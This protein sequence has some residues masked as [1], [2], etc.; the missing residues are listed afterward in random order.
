MQSKFEKPLFSF[1]DYLKRVD[2][3]E[4]LKF[5]CLKCGKEFFTRHHDGIHK[6]CPI[7][8]PTIKEFASQ[9]EKELFDFVSYLILGWQEN[10]HV[11][12]EN[13]YFKSKKHFYTW[14]NEYNNIKK[15]TH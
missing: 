10:K 15:L 8:Y 12:C 6:H 9:Q 11:Q 2:D 7:C 1:D 4:K 14:V 13:P 3:N 5:K